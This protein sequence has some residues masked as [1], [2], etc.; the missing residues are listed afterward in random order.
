MSAPKTTVALLS[1]L[2]LAFAAGH[3]EAKKKRHHHPH[4]KSIELALKGATSLTG[5]VAEISAFDPRTKRLFVVDGSAVLKIVDLSDPSNPTQLPGT[6]DVAAD[7]LAETGLAAADANSIAIKNGLIAVAVAAD[8]VTDA[9]FVAFYGTNGAYKFSCRAG[10]LPDMLTFT[11]DGR[12]ILVA[13]EGEPDGVDPVGSV[14]VIDVRKILRAGD[15]DASGAVRTAGFERFDGYEDALRAKGVRLFPGKSVSQDVEPEYIAV[16]DNS[17]L[18][19]VTL[20]EANAMA[21]LSVRSARILR[22]L[23]LGLKDHSVAGN[24]LDASDRD[25]GINIQTWPV[26]GMYMPDAIASF[27]SKGRTYLVTANEGDDRGENERIKDLDLDPSAFPNAADLQEDENLGRL[28]VSSIDGDTDNDGDYDMLFAYGARSFTVWDGFGRRVH[29][30]GDFIGRKTAEAAPA[31]FNADN[32]DPGEFDTRSDAKG[33]EPEGATTGEA[34]GRTYAFIGLERGPG[35]VMAFDMSKP[36]SPKFVQYVRRDADVSP[37]GLL[38]IDAKDS[39]SR[40]PLLVLSHEVS[41]TL[42]VYEIRPKH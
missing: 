9:G 12:K 19:W 41:G 17:R 8:P 5:G 11:P 15:C 21:L 28:A 4:A 31:L 26:Y 1:C 35:G 39:P 38:F 29:D 2:C 20:Q 14:S 32:G 16:S 27:R 22:I 42:T 7:I 34:Y 37:E 36:W 10:A 25:G 18:A 33:A 23:P 13:N 3:A 6:L 24:G 40:K 30:S